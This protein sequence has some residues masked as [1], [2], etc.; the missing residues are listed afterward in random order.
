M[1]TASSDSQ[2][3]LIRE[4][5]ARAGLDPSQPNDRC[6]YFEAH[7]TGTPAG[8]PQE[9]GAIYKAFFSS[10][11]QSGIQPKSP[12]NGEIKSDQNILLVGSIKTVIGH[13]EGTAGIAGLMK[14]GLAIQNS[15]IPPNMHFTRLNPELKPYYDNL[16]VPIQLRDWPETADGIPRRASVNSFGFGGAN[17][18]AI[19]ESYEPELGQLAASD[20]SDQHN[21]KANTKL[22]DTTPSS[23]HVF[24]FS[25]ASS[26][27]LTAQLKSYRS[28]LEENPDFDMN[29]LLWSLFRRTAHSFRI[30]F[31]AKSIRSLSTQIAEVLE[32]SQTKKGP[33]GI[34]ASPKAPREILGVFTGQGAQWATMGRELIISSHFAKSVIE[35]LEKSLAQ[36]PSSDAPDWSLMAELMAS[37]EHSRIADSVISQPLC[38]AVQIMVVELLRQ[39]GIRFNAVVGHSS[40]EIA[41]AYV[42]GFLSASDAIRVA[43]YRGKYTPLAKGRTGGMIAVGTDMQD[44]I[45]MCSLPKLRNRA[46]FAASNSSASVTISGDIDAIKLVEVV[47]SDE[48]KFARALKVDTAY[49]SFHMAACSDPYI[50]A[51]RRCGI[52]VTEP[53]ADACAW[54]TS[55]VETNEQVTMSMS[56]ALEGQYW[57]DNMLQPVLFSQALTS[58]VTARGTPGV[59]LEVGP[60]PALKG[61]A[62]LTIEEVVGAVPYFG[63]LARGHDDA[64]A[65]MSTVGS[66]WSVLGAA[67]IP[68]IRDFQVAYCQEADFSISKELPSYSWDHDR[69]VWNETRISKAHRLRPSAKHALLG[70]RE[71][72]EGEGERRWRN[73]LSPKEMAWLRGHQIQGQMV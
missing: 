14:A 8:D 62:S 29:T 17:A 67:A 59:V 72:D 16:K 28:F 41:C 12:A 43:Y 36:L 57:C 47:A 27:S 2:A 68:N 18:H 40:G 15:A 13:T 71:V 19:I 60:H 65:L 70:V 30:S 11:H 10:E 64:L 9:A 54:Y 34:R 21:L 5:Y 23:P 44:A 51:L 50:S 33:L 73:Y 7:G 25:A 61:P 69:V 24:V 56:S 52:Q 53:S 35:A 42:S 6:Q 20:P 32:Q 26:K 22:L 45:D 55:V 3:S 58:A 4:T 31:A 63:T 39:A 49:H 66:L 48:S 38:T 46:Q 37:K 1:P